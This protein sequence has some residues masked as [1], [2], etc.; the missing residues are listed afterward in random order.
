MLESIPLLYLLEARSALANPQLVCRVGEDSH[1]R[2][3]KGGQRIRMGGHCGGL[4]GVS[5][6]G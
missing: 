2:L 1:I 5:K 6:S 3:R 4:V